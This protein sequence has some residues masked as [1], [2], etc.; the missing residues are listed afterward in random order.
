M[1]MVAYMYNEEDLTDVL[2]QILPQTPSSGP[3]CFHQNNA[4]P[5]YFPQYLVPRSL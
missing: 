2:A 1:L 5:M 3:K 4:L